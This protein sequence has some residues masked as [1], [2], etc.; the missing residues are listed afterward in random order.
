MINFHVKSRG[1]WQFRDVI[2][3]ILPINCC[4]K[5]TLTNSIQVPRLHMISILNELDDFKCSISMLKLVVFGSF[6]T[7][8]T[9]I[10]PIRFL[11]KSSQIAVKDLIYTLS[12][13]E[14]N[15]MIINVQFRC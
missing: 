14:M 5:K 9:Q 13:Y 4:K 1:F 15:W 8:L 2:T 10:L 11:Q 3:R 6:V 7:S 12:T